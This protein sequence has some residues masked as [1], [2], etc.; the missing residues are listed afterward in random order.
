MSRPEVY[1]S[2]DV[3]TD[4][5]IPG[6]HSMLSLGAAAFTRERGLIATHAANLETLPEATGHPQT[7]AWWA[8]QTTAWAACRTDLQTPVTAMTR[9]ADWL[10]GLPGKPVFAG[11]PASFDFLFV[12][13]Y[14]HRYAGRSPFSFAA[15]DLKSLALG[16]LGGE[17]RG[18]RKSRMPKDWFGPTAHS[19]VALDDA[20]GQGELL[21]RML[22]ARDAL[23]HGS[24][25]KSE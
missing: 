8:G 15:L 24:S 7:M 21:L 13:W 18:I 4:G 20:I 11:Y 10:E 5:P 12:Y 6:P 17:F 23:L 14:L 3:E 2:V 9:F 19:H 16:L 22:A 1:V 25:M